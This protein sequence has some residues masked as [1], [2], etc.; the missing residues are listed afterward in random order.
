M[1]VYDF[2]TNSLSTSTTLTDGDVW[3]FTLGTDHLYENPY[4]SAYGESHTR[5]IWTTFDF[6]LN[7]FWSAFFE[8]RYDDRK[9][10]MTDQIYGVRQRLGNSWEIEY[11][12]RYRQDA[13]DESD[14]SFRVG[15]TLLMF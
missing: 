12:V 8:L 5:Q 6:R 13:G 7:S 2:K 1:D 10:L 9:N 14:F 4:S 11:S 3:A 15:A